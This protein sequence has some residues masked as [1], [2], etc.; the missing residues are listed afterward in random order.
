MK[1]VYHKKHVDFIDL[2]DS[3]C[4]NV[5]STI[6][7]VRFIKFVIYCIKKESKMHTAELSVLESGII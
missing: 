2:K 7:N 5:V 6:Y 1:G 4:K 3:I